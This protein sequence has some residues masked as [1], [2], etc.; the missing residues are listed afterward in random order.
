MSDFH[1]VT[2]MLGETIEYLAPKSGGVYVDATLG[3]GG[4]AEA[5]LEASAP[6]GRL[7][8]IDRD[9]RALE[10][11]R[12]RLARFG[13]RVAFMHGEM[14]DIRALIVAAGG[15]RVDGIVADIGVSS[16]QLDDASRGFSLR[17][18]GPLDMRMDPTTGETAR[19]LIQRLDERE[20]ADLLF[21]YGEEKKSH[22]VARSIMRALDEGHLDTTSDLRRACV[23]ALGPRRGRIDPATRTFQALRIVVNAELEQLE[24][25]VADLAEVLVD[26]G[27]GVVISFHSLED[28]IVKWAF[29]N[30]ARLTPLTKRP[31]VATDDERDANPRARSAKLR[32]ARR[33]PREAAA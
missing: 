20:L 32:A 15:R 22:R 28:R 12:T 17:A 9:P 26:G 4:H 7:I 33:V 30:D 8:G 16:P 21:Q 13:E 24:R 25:L 18:D 2:V 10:A 3:G 6:D 29:R 14:A 19:E 27:V 1:H 23:R 31:R 5:I 11:A